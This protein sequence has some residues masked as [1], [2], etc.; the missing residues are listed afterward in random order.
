[1]EYDIVDTVSTV[2]IKSLVRLSLVYGETSGYANRHTNKKSVRATCIRCVRG[3]DLATLKRLMRYFRADLYDFI[4]NDH[5]ISK[6]CARYG[7]LEI[8]EWLIS[9]FAIDTHWGNDTLT[10]LI[11]TAF[12]CGFPN[13]YYKL[14]KYRYS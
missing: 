12:I 9:T 7:R 3:G 4:V 1:M 8:L 11:N 13:I 2:N 14:R 5:V 10:T 6:R